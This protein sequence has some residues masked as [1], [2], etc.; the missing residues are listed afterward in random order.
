[1]LVSD[2]PRTTIISTIDGDCFIPVTAARN[3]GP[4]SR[5]FRFFSD[6]NL[7]IDAVNL[8]KSQFSLGNAASKS[9]KIAFV[10]LVKSAV[11]LG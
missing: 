7:L 9:S 3:G 6:R 11:A 4:T 5:I 8:S 10:S 1:M 2:R